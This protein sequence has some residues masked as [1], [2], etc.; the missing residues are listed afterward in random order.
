MKRMAGS[1]VVWSVVALMS[2]LVQTATAQGAI[3]PDFL[4]TV[5]SAHDFDATL[6][7]LE[8]AIEGENLMVVNEVNPQQ[9]LRMIGMR[10]GGML[11]L[12]TLVAHILFGVALGL[13]IQ[14]FLREEDRGWLVPFV[15]GRSA[16]TATESA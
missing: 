2:G 11:F 9:M 5:R 8:Q 16:R 12:L 7:A 4:V 10:T 3:P 14:A 1:F 6:A 15:L 13:L